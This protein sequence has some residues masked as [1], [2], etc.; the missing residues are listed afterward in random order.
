MEPEPSWKCSNEELGTAGFGNEVSSAGDVN[1]DGFDDVIVGGF[2][3]A[4][5]FFGSASGLSTTPAWISSCEQD[6]AQYGYCVSSAGDVNADGYDDVIVGALTYDSAGELAGK[7][8]LYLGSETGPVATPA[9]TSSGDDREGALFCKVSSAGDVNNDGF[10]D[11]IVGASHQDIVAENEGKAFL[12]LGSTSGLMNEPA[13]ASSG[14]EFPHAA[15]GFS[16]STAQDV[17]G[18]GFDDV[19]IGAAYER[20]YYSGEGKVFLFLGSESGLSETPAWVSRGDK[21]PGGWLGFSVASAGD[22]NNDGFA[23]VIFGAPGDI[24]S[25]NGWP[26]KAYMHTGS[27][28]GIC[29]PGAACDDGDACTH[30]DTCSDGKCSGTAYT[31]DDDNPCTADTC[32]GDGTCSHANVDGACDDEDPC[33]QG[34]TCLNGVCAGGMDHCLK[35]YGCSCRSINKKPQSAEMAVLLGPVGFLW[36]TLR[37]RREY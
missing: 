15:F 4:F 21:K 18:D 5:V 22:V 27:S 3:N 20:T 24:M 26:G 32:S 9:W 11:V 29:D 34:E 28:Y 30:D 19:I 1:N 13:W 23:D 35:S 31:C 10:D 14:D 17:N 36:A 25:Y 37:R 2:N 16:V 6:G 8:F 33:T 12:Y 7:V